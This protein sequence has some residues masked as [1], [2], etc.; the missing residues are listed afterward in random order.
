MTPSHWAGVYQCWGRE[1][2]EAALRLVTGSVGEQPRAA[3]AEL[4]CVDGAANPY[5]VVGA[6]I[7]AGLAGM[8]ACLGLPPEAHGDPAT[9]PPGKLEELGVRRLP[10]SSREALEHFGS[11]KLLLEA[12]GEMLYDA[13]YAVRQAETEA[14]AEVDPQD[15]AAATRWRY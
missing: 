4:K 10:Q 5:L 2:R 11:S 3:N 8:D 9:W 1:N 15:I 14:F 12:M 7:A 13:F 6:V